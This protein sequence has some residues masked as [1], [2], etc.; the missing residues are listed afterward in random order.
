MCLKIYLI[1][2]FSRLVYDEWQGFR[3]AGRR[4]LSL[5]RLQ[6]VQL[7]LEKPV[8]DKK[9]LRHCGDS[10]WS[11]YWNN[12]TV[13]ESVRKIRWK[14]THRTHYHTMYNQGTYCLEANVRLRQFTAA[15][16]PMEV[17]G[18]LVV[19]VTVA[20]L[21]GIPSYRCKSFPFNHSTNLKNKHTPLFIPYPFSIFIRIYNYTYV[22]VY[23]IFM[24]IDILLTLPS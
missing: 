19:H 24:S 15:H 18:E 16:L 21:F 11:F 7:L 23:V 1:I 6:E 8:F 4:I 5:L 20:M 10:C 3:R 14:T 9:Y 13:F 22:I 17:G 2:T 12:P